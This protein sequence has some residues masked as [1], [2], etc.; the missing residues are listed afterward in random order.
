MKLLNESPSTDW[1]TPP[2]GSNYQGYIKFG[3]G[4][5]KLSDE[6]REEIKKEWMAETR[7]DS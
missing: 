1:M 6:E 5:I 2:P 3:C 4:I 7:E